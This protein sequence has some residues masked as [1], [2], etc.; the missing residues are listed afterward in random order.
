M[1]NPKLETRKAVVENAVPVIIGQPT[2]Q[3]LDRMDDEL[4][5]IASNVHSNLGGGLHGHAGLVK[6]AAEYELIVPCTPFLFPANPGFYPQ[7]NIPAAQCSQREGEHNGL[8]AQ[9][10]T[11][12][13]APNKG[14]KDLILRRRLKGT[15]C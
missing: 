6:S 9:F 2:N 3:D 15:F 10:Q 1:T 11:C 7:G 12:V 8:I 5:E 4:M 13:G 14:L